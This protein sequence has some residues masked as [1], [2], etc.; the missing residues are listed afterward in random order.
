[1]KGGQAARPTRRQHTVWRR[2]LRAWA[3]Q[4]QI[5][6]AMAGNKFPASLM[7]VAQQRDFYRLEEMTDDDIHKL[8]KLIVEPMNSPLLRQASVEWIRMFDQLRTIRTNLSRLGI[9]APKDLEHASIQAEESLHGAIEENAV[10]LLDR[11]LVADAFCLNDDEYGQ[12]MHFMMTQYFRT[13]RMKENLRRGLGDKYDGY[14]TRSMPALRHIMA[15]AAAWTLIAERKTW[16]ACLL[17]NDSSVPLITGDQPVINLL[18][19]ELPDG[20]NVEDCEFYYPLSPWKALVVLK[21]ERYAGGK[22]TE[23]SE[24]REFNRLI[25]LAA[26][27]QAFGA[28]MSDLND[29]A[30]LVG[31]HVSQP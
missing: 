26:E 10:P 23:D 20:V 17:T 11:L 15:T 8:M 7:K 1:M 12:F 3:K 19:V 21:S 31:R 14:V 4:E 25:A 5:W 9:D 16:N 22:I 30:E 27:R 18:A 6:C 13:S 24:A 28:K 2:Y 29:V